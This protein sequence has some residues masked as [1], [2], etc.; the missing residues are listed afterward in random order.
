MLRRRPPIG[1][2]LAGG[3]GIRM[4]GSKLNVQLR[5]QPLIEYPLAALR[6]A[7]DDVAVIAKP[8]VRLPPLRGVMLWIEPETPQHPLVG[9]VEALSLAGGR[10]VLVCPA[11]LPFVTP[12]L[13]RRLAESS[14]DQAPAV[15]ASLE[16][17][18]QPLLGCYQPIAGKLLEAAARAGS[19]SVREA[20]AAIGPRL[21]EVD[22]PDELFNV[23]SPEDLL[24]AAAM[25]DG[26]QTTS[27]R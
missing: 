22:N 20:V 19:A 9:L 10:P 11:D 23:N 2:V 26:G 5:G 16:G 12:G 14:A 4:G 15:I 3:R 1:V 24:V 6:A 13:I 18:T 25:L 17:R 7:L 8:D 27:R 21:L